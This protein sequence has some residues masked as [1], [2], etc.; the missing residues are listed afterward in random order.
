MGGFGVGGCSS[1]GM[2]T[3]RHWALHR[4][5]V[6]GE[7]PPRGSA[8]PYPNAVTC[9]GRGAFRSQKNPTANGLM[10]AARQAACC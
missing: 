1:A 10:L 6:P 8:C 7:D 2:A 9:S 3:L 4:D 5:P